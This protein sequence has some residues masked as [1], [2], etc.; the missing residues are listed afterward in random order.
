M[1]NTTV[2]DY[3]LS[4]RVNNRGQRWRKLSENEEVIEFLDGINNNDNND[5]NTK[6]NWTEETTKPSKANTESKEEKDEEKDEE[7]GKTNEEEFEWSDE[8]EEDGSI[9]NVSD[10]NQEF[11]STTERRRGLVW[12]LAQ[13]QPMKGFN[14][15]E[16]IRW[17]D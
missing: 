3:I 7:L 13:K 16:I 4:N 17:K 10:K 15:R 11:F 14:W 9:N 8:K 6:I 5:S 2:G 1:R 12:D